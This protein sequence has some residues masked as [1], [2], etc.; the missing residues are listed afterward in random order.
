MIVYDNEGVRGKNLTLIYD[1]LMR[2]KPTSVEAES[3]FPQPG[4]YASV[5]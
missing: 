2:L 5:L 1:Y 4:I 3:F